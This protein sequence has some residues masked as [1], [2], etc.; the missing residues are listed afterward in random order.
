MATPARNAAEFFFQFSLVARKMEE[1][2]CGPATITIANGKAVKKLGKLLP[3]S[4]EDHRC[5]S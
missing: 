3:P 2:I 4:V 5:A 1:R